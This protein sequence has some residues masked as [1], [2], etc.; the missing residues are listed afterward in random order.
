MF[1]WNATYQKSQSAESMVLKKVSIQL[2]S[3]Q[4]IGDVWIA[5]LDR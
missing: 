4:S 3:K 5:Q 2:S 1:F